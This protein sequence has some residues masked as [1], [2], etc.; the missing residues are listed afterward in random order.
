M[1]AS[2]CAALRWTQAVEKVEDRCCKPVEPEVPHQR[3]GIVR[4]DHCHELDS[5][6]RKSAGRPES[7]DPA[8][9]PGCRSRGNEGSEQQF[10]FTACPSANGRTMFSRELVC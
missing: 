7:G 2:W 5:T 8:G 10:A 3:F 9:L 4:R 6:E 1:G